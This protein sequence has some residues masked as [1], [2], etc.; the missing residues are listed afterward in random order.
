MLS[1]Q[2]VDGHGGDGLAQ[3]EGR[4]ASAELIDGSNE[5]TTRRVRHARRFGMDALTC[6]DVWQTDPCGQHLYSDLACLRGGDVFFDDGDHFGAVI[7]CDE[8]SL[9]THVRTRWAGLAIS[10]P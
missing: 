1:Q 10:G 3:F 5:I 6:Q 8:N 2:I 7:A 9:V 4:H